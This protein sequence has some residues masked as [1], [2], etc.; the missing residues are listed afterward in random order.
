MDARKRSSPS[1]HES[2]SSMDDSMPSSAGSST[3]TNATS[4]TLELEERFQ[5][6]M[7]ADAPEEVHDVDIEE[8]DQE[9]LDALCAREMF[10]LTGK[11]REDVLHDIHGVADAVEETPSFC[12]KQVQL[13]QQ[14]LNILV[15]RP[16]KNTGAYLK[17]LHQNEEYVESLYLMF[18]RAD[19]WKPKEAAERLVGFLEKK[20]DL[21]GVHSLT[22][23]ITIERHMTTN[24]RQ[25]LESG[26]FQLL[27]VR[28]AA[29]RAILMGI[30]PLRN[31]KH[32][33]NLVREKT[34]LINLDSNAT[35]TGTSRESSHL[36]KRAFFYV[37]MAALEDVETQ[38]MGIVMIGFNMGSKRVVD[39]QAA[40]AVN[41]LKRYVPFRVGSIHYCYD[42]MRFRVMMTMAMLLMGAMQRVRFRAHFGNY[43]EVSYVLSTYGIPTSVLPI[44]PDGEPKVKNHKSWL[45]QRYEQESKQAKGLLPQQII[46]IPNRSDVLLGRGKPIQGRIGGNAR[47]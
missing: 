9:E 28:D 39:R 45:K 6:A 18:L 38:K 26:F 44:L 13:L 27:S 20:V 16:R 42:D 41:S 5:R 37:V 22:E 21:F 33:D 23:K 36:Q 1:P 31:Y 25:A 7:I 35:Q 10:A 4:T 32:V 40:F 43:T 30:P 29:G 3:S 15:S 46:V 17:A 47:R 8:I 19:Q 14:E 2:S 34:S 24:D 12:Q 11:E